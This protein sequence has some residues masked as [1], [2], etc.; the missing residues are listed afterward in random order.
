MTSC[1]FLCRNLDLSRYD[2]VI[3]TDPFL[4]Y[5]LH[6]YS[7][8]S[9]FSIEVNVRDTIQQWLENTPLTNPVERRQSIVFQWVL[10]I[11]IAF[12]SIDL[13]FTFS[14]LF[15][16]PPAANAAPLPTIVR[17]SLLLLDIGGVLLWITPVA[18]LVLLRRGRFNLAVMVASVGLLLSH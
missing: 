9:R 6:Y 3:I 2:F 7:I 16:A 12:A 13:L 18:A 10:I 5:A 17:V 4:C 8:C 14:A 11:W 1:A 15:A